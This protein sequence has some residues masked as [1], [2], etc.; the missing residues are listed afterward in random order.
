MDYYTTTGVSS[1]FRQ[2][3]S[4]DDVQGSL[5][6]EIESEFDTQGNELSK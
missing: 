2:Q 1:G 3:G 4:L 6:D 5:M